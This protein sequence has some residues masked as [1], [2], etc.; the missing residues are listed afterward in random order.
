MADTAATG[1][2]RKRSQAFQLGVVSAV[3]LALTSCGSDDSPDLRCVDTKTFKNVADRLCNGQPGNGYA[4]TDRY[5]WY[6]DDGHRHG[7]AAGGYYGHRYTGPRV[8]KGSHKS[9][10][11][12]WGGFGGHGHSSGG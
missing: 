2:R 7:T 8:S 11:F 1:A 12:H 9:S 6:E 3:A 4:S 10:G 5:Q